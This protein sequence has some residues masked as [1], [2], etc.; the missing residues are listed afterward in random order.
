MIIIIIRRYGECTSCIIGG[1][2][3]VSVKTL[4]EQKT[5]A[6]VKAINDVQFVIRRTYISLQYDNQHVINVITAINY[7]YSFSRGTRAQDD[8]T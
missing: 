1:R 7:N 8:G 5:L 6:R 2:V 3:S 4:F